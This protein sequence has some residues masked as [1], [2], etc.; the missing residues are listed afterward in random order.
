[1]TKT[2]AQILEHAKQLEKRFDAARDELK[3]TR[4]ELRALAK[5]SV[6]TEAQKKEARRIAS[7]GQTR[8]RKSSPKPANKT[9]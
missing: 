4:D 2:P 7:K 9:R 6:F 8:R 5:T 3:K 1:M